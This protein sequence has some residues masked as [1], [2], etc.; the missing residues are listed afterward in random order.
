MTIAGR[1][2][3]A[4]LAAIVSALLLTGCAQLSN[5][6]GTASR[7]ELP[8]A[9]AS[10]TPAVAESP[11]T[12][13]GRALPPE[14][15]AV[16]A[17]V[18][19]P[20]ESR[21]APV[22]PPTP[23]SALPG[24][25]RT[26]SAAVPA[27]ARLY[28]EVTLT[29]DITWRG[30]IAVEG[31]VTVAPQT[32]LTLEPGTVVR[33]RRTVAGV[34]RSPVLLVQG[35]IVARGNEAAPVLFAS[36]FADP[37]AGDWQGIVLLATE[38]KNSFEHSR[39]EGAIIGLDAAFSSVTLKETSFRACAIG[40]R[41]QDSVFALTGGGASGCGLG[42]EL[43]ESEADIREASF[44]GNGS[45]V[46]GRNGSLALEGVLCADNRETG[47][48][49]AG[50]RLK[51]SASIFDT[52]GQGIVLS[53]CEGSIGRSRIAAN[54]EV[55]VSLTASRVKLFGNEIVRN[56]VVGLKVDDGRGVAW[57]NTFAGNG[58]YDIACSGSDDFRAIANWWGE[59]APLALEQR[60]TQ[61]GS[62]RVLTAPALAARPPALNLNSI[63]K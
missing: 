15:K 59:A 60:I 3:V 14:D 36:A 35:R 53:G 28:R 48:S 13:P 31:S 12:A 50:T 43:D 7:G 39:I 11:Q 41:F 30:E 9:P 24:V 54:R 23:R 26:V 56:G 22:P 33:F 63:A 8:T 55:G 10:V 62:G 25:T 2:V 19:L 27:A 4:A 49:L 45:G 29:E 18:S 34:D 52:N 32:T 61:T 38:K 20:E 57:G 17:S 5:L 42:V 46:A 47:V 16:P 37:L 51:V 40:G 6:M 58:R 1:S 21:S 44:R